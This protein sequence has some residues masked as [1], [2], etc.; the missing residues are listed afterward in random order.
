MSLMPP[1]STDAI[2][3]SR[4]G[5]SATGSREEHAGAT[6]GGPHQRPL[7][8]RWSR[9][10]H[11]MHRRRARDSQ[12]RSD[13]I[14]RHPLASQHADQRP[15]SPREDSPILERSV[16]DR[17]VAA[18]QCPS[19]IVGV[20]SFSPTSRQLGSSQAARSSPCVIRHGSDEPGVHRGEWGSGVHHQ[21][22]PRAEHTFRSRIDVQTP[23]S[24][25][26]ALAAR[27]A[28]NRR[29]DPRARSGVSSFGADDG[30]RTRDPHLG[31]VMLYQLSHV[32]VGTHTIATA[33]GDAT[34]ER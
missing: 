10:R 14:L 31:K 24:A 11:G 16:V 26:R 6:K 18:E 22:V 33:R 17:L 30:I 25:S 21:T 27:A 28:K 23:A 4:S 12:P 20:E 2:G 29:A 1:P 15:S 19:G 9:R 7:T 8:R 3:S 32:R 13:P 34:L 5:R